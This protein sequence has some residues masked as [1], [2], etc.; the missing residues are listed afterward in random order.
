MKQC[1]C[2]SE[3]V[4]FIRSKHRN[5]ADRGKGVTGYKILRKP[6]GQRIL[7]EEIK[8]WRILKF[9]VHKENCL[10]IDTFAAGLQFRGKSEIKSSSRMFLDDLLIINVY[11]NSAE[12][13]TLSSIDFSYIESDYKVEIQVLTEWVNSNPGIIRAQWVSPV[14]DYDKIIDYATGLNE[15]KVLLSDDKPRFL[16]IEH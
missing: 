10:S 6:S 4:D 14:E 5:I 13:L 9:D 8:G 3:I 2:L 1:K 7:F 15:R 16:N 11:D 12:F